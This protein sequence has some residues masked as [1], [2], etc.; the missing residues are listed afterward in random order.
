MTPSSSAFPTFPASTKQGNEG[1]TL[2][3]YFAAAAMQ[4]LLASK[5]SP[6]EVAKAAVK[7]ADA[8]LEE[9]GVT[10]AGPAQANP[11]SEGL[12]ASKQGQVK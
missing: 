6:G 1:M 5:Y 11:Y 4:G 12:T 3:H 7:V 10:D 8:L 9:L 2:R